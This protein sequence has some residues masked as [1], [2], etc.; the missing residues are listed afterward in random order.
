MNASSPGARYR[1]VQF[2]NLILKGFLDAEI[3]FSHVGSNG[4]NFLKKA[5]FDRTYDINSK[6][7]AVAVETIGHFQFEVRHPVP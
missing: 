6:V 2:V 7:A 5:L 1:I 3:V 4:E